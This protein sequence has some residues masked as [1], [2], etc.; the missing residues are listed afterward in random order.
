VGTL[1]NVYSDTLVK[2]LFG[3]IIKARD[4]GAL[5]ATVIMVYVTIDTMAFLSM[6]LSKK[7]NG[8]TEFIDWVNK[9]MKTESSQSYQYDGKDMWGARCAKLHSY[10]SESEYAKDNDCKMYGYVN[11]LNHFYNPQESERLVLIGIHRLVSDFGDALISFLRDA[12]K[13]T[14]LKYTLDKRLEKV[15]RQFDINYSKEK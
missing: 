14:D 10:A 11:G 15:C 2:G 5:S 9:Y 7:K 8:S 3:E 13:N 6:P 4:A 12:S 1:D